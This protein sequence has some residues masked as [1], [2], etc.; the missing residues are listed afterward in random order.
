MYN[1]NLLRFLPTSPLGWIQAAL[2]GAVLAAAVTYHLVTLNAEYERG[3]VAARQKCSE[4]AAA[5]RQR[6]ETAYQLRARR[7]EA[8]LNTLRA[9]DQKLSDEDVRVFQSLE[10]E[11]G[12]QKDDPVCWPASIVKEINR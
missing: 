10:A 4:D 12:R 11:L 6:A 2:V 5:V 8:K 9:Q 7:L 3:A 1:V